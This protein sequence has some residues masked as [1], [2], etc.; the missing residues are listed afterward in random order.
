MGFLRLFNHKKATDSHPLNND[1]SSSFASLPRRSENKYYAPEKWPNDKTMR[2]KFMNCNLVISQQKKFIFLHIPK[3]AGKSIHRGILDKHVADVVSRPDLSPLFN[4]MFWNTYFRFTVVRNPFDRMVSCYHYQ[5]ERIGLYPDATFEEF[6]TDYAWDENGFATNKHWLPQVDHVFDDDR[7]LVDYIM[8]FERID[9]DWGEVARRT[10]L[11][12]SLP[13]TNTSKR[14]DYLQYYN[15]E[16]RKIVAEKYAKDL[17]A[18]G[19]SF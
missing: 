9:V 5:K 1:S 3:N 11:E 4:D 13:K 12:V 10:G 15:D 16:T 8:R 2:F 14:G 6:V 18:F 17:D 19:Y 7:C